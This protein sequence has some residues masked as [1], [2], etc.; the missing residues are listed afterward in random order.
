MEE[1][2]FWIIDLIPSFI[3]LHF[4]RSFLLGIILLKNILGFGARKDIRM[5]S[6]AEMRRP[7]LLNWWNLCRK[8]AK[9]EA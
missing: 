2:Y 3:R 8:A 7:S 1:K 4:V 9:S 6:K 5:Q